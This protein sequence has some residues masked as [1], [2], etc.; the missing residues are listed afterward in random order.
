LENRHSET[1]NEGKIVIPTLG[2]ETKLSERGMGKTVIP[3]EERVRNLLAR[4]RWIASGPD[5]TNGR[6]MEIGGG[7]RSSVAERFLAQ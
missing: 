7:A 2:T 1:R 6:K 5:L 4:G 3:S